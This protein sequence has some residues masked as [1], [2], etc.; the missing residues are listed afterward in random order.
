MTDAP[1]TAPGPQAR[2]PLAR[3]RD[4]RIVAGVCAG[5]ARY[6]GLNPLVV[7]LA[8][9]ALTVAGG[10]GVVLYVAAWLM[11]PL[12]GDQRSMAQSALSDRRF[13]PTEIVAVGAVVLGGLL[14]LRSTG[15]WFGDA[16]VWPVVLSVVGLAVI[17]RQAGDDDRPSLLR[18]VD[19][20]P[21]GGGAAGGAGAGLGARRPLPAGGAG[22]G[23]W[24]AWPSSSSAS[25]CSWPP[26]TPSRRFARACWP[27]PASSP[28]WP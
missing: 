10:T 11:L 8:V 14:L 19:R 27:P 7:R 4:E 6:I 21:R 5:L 17:W 12:E 15:I 9:V 1:P 13:D 3:S 23:S 25:G 16:I 2:P 22:R 18:V 28:G 20:L 26:A 24:A